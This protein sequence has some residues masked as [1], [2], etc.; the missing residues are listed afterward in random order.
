MGIKDIF[1]KIGKGAGELKGS[2]SD[3]F[4]NS[5]TYKRAKPV[6]PVK[7]VENDMYTRA[8]N[9]TKVKYG[10]TP[11]PY[12]LKA[13]NQQESSGIVDESDLNLSM[14]MTDTARADLGDDYL[15]PTSIDNV[16]QNASNYLAQRARGVLDSGEE[17]DLS[18][19]ENY[20]KW[21]VQKYV[22]LKPGESREIQGQIVTYEDIIKLFKNQLMQAQQ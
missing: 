18:T 10:F 20:S 5:V 11:P 15:E 21:Y 8:N 2:I 9:A 19:P 13:V 14:G 1:S 12:F 3:Y 7:P 22:G 16:V 4:D 6:E 17:Y